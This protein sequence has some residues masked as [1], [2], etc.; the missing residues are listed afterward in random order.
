MSKLRKAFNGLTSLQQRAVTA[1]ILAPLF[2]GA[3]Y[4]GSWIFALILIA[5]ALLCYREWL[6]LVQTSWPDISE[7]TAYAFLALSLMLTYATSVSLALLVLVIGFVVIAFLAHLYIDKGDRRAP[8]WLSLGMFYAGLPFLAILWLRQYGWE[9]VALVFFHVWATDTLAYFVGRSVKGPKLAPKIS[10]NKT[11]SGLVGGM[12]GG[13]FIMGLCA[14]A[15]D[16]RHAWSYFV[17]GAVLAV[18]AQIGDF[19]ES[20][21]KRRAGVKDSGTVIPGHGG[22][23]DRVDGL[24][25]SAPVFA[26]IFWALL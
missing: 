16:F 20:Y 5:M 13:A 4:I 26:L 17:I 12:L 22:I 15:W 23:L 19:F 11:W 3:L 7:Y 24:L 2:F 25:A 6:P 21:V 1:I 18:I 14:Y 8:P 9:P 10:P